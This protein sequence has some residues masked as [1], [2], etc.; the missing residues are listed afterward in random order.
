MFD[1]R[2]SGDRLL[3][4][5]LAQLE[6]SDIYRRPMQDVMQMLREDAQSYPPEL[7]NQRYI[8]TFTLRRGWFARAID[9]G[10]T[11]LGEVGNNVRYGPQVMDRF[12]QKPIHQGRWQTTRDILTENT[13]RIVD[14][15][16][17]WIGRSISR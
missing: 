16:A 11:L 4:A 7:P 5:R 9:Q 1:V 13:R 10:D 15:F 14:T 12:D 3:D 2:L 17:A 8:R 6:R